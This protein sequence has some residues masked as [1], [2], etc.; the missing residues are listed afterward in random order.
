[1]AVEFVRGPNQPG[2]SGAVL[3]EIT[4]CVATFPLLLACRV[5]ELSL[6]LGDG[7]VRRQRLGRFDGLNSVGERYTENY[8]RQLVVAIE[9][10]PA[11]FGG[12]DQQHIGVAGGMIH[13]D[14]RDRERAYRGRISSTFI[15][16]AAVMRGGCR[17]GSCACRV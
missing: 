16:S 2:A 13:E 17:S 14:R 5:S 6:N 1:M 12:L 15:F 7:R 3:S 8:S 9:A 11:F 10:T 4:I